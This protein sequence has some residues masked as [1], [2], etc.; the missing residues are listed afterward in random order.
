M[1]TNQENKGLFSDKDIKKAK[2]LAVVVS[3]LLVAYY[4]SNT[5]LNVLQI[6]KI[7]NIK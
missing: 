4:L 5:Y 7:K 2:V 1:E 6:K 3:G